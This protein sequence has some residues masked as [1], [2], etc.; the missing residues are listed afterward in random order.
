MPQRRVA[1][2]S[3]YYPGNSYVDWLAF[4]GY[5]FT[6]QSPSQ[7]MKPTYDIIANFHA[8]K[9][10][11]IA[12]TGCREYA[13]KPNWISTLYTDTVPNE[14]PRVKAVCWFDVDDVELYPLQYNLETQADINAYKAVA[15]RPEWGWGAATKGDGYNL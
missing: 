13:G 11:M 6:S 9:P 15:D 2:L 8:T 7:V 12:E 5:N 14:M 1:S 4:D 3:D 10:F